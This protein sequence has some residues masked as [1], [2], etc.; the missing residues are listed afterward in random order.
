VHN[1]NKF[2][3]LAIAW[4]LLVTLLSLVSIG[5]IGNSIPIAGKDKIVHFV[6]YFVFVIVWFSY[7][8]SKNSMI[9]I[10]L[11]IVLIAIVYGIIMEI[12]Q[13]VFTQNRVADVYDALANSAGAMFAFFYLKKI[14]RQ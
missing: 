8:K 4:T 14:K 12:C 13:G 7:L 6:F 11:K 10:T 3:I 1:T 5:K 2:L 9:I